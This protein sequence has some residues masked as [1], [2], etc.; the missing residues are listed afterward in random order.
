MGRVWEEVRAQGT[1]GRRGIG[2][3]RRLNQ[4]ICPLSHF[5]TNGHGAAVMCAAPCSLLEDRKEV[6]AGCRVRK[7]LCLWSPQQI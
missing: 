4:A 1:S 7:G 3:S 6:Q 2:A 5:G